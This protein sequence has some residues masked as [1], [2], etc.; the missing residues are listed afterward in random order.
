MVAKKV[1]ATLSSS[2][3]PIVCLGETQEQRLAGQTQRVIA[4]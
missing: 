3:M 1:K 4:T 2:L